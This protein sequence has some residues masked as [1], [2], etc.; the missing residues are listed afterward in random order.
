MSATSPRFGRRHWDYPVGSDVVG[1]GV[2]ASQGKDSDTVLKFSTQYRF[3]DTKMIYALYSEGFRLGGNNDRPGAENGILPARVQAGHAQELRGGL[4]DPLAGPV[5]AAQPDRVLHGMEGHPAQPLGIERRQS[6]GGCGAPSTAARQSRKASNSASA[7][8]PTDN[9]SIDASA[10][11]ADPEFSEDTFDPDYDPTDPDNDSPAIVAGTTMPIS[12]EEKYW[13]AASYTF[14]N[15][16]GMQGNLWTRIAWSYQSEI[17]NNLDAI[18]DFQEAV[19][20][21][22]RA[23]A[24]EELIPS[25]TSTTLQLGFTHDNGWE[26]ALVVRNLFDERGVDYMSSSDYSSGP[27]EAVLPWTDEPVQAHQV[28]AASTHDRAVLQQEVV[29]V[30]L[31]TG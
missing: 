15:A 11:I 5:A 10:F 31:P 8:S 23:T 1:G 22:E 9:F 26:T 30:A 6:R 25:Y 16:F 3:S 7:G 19:T 28:A 14:P 17:W 2:V 4:Q 18:S 27:D 13:V 29:S 20:P 21:E 24:L 12:P